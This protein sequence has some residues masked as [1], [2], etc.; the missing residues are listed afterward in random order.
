MRKNKN[1]TP[2]DILACPNLFSLTFALVTLHGI[3][4]RLSCCCTVGN[5]PKQI[6]AN[7]LKVVTSAL[8]NKE[9]TFFSLC[10]ATTQIAKRYKCTNNVH[11]GEAEEKSSM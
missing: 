3:S 5:C 1:E 10:P 8:C 2:E 9:A 4:G 7:C 11:V 6:L